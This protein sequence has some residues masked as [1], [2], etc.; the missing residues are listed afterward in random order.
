[1]RRKVANLEQRLKKP[2]SIQLSLFDMNGCSMGNDPRFMAW[3]FFAIDSK[4]NKNSVKFETNDIIIEASPSAIGRA[5]QEDKA[6]LIYLISH[7]KEELEAGVYPNQKIRV[8]AYDYFK[9]TNKPFTGY[10]YEKFNEMMTRLQGTNIY[11]NIE[12]GG[13]GIDEWFS[14]LKS[15]KVH[16]YKNKNG[17][18]SVNIFEVELC[19]WLYNGVVGDQTFIGYSAEYFDMSPIMQRLYEIAKVDKSND[20]FKIPFLYLR[21]LVGSTGSPK[22]FKTALHM[23]KDN[24]VLSDHDIEFFDVRRPDLILDKKSKISYEHQMVVFGRRKQ[25]NELIKFPDLREIPF[26]EHRVVEVIGNGG[27]Y[28]MS[29]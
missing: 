7:M 11:T 28:E 17:N 10:Y 4:S 22:N 13:E 14:W 24:N 15:V 16:Y 5:T 25:K 20:F 29:K 12:M 19:D 3:S 1:M 8:T 6:F 23:C 9:K 21:D 18:K 2:N 27:E 26:W